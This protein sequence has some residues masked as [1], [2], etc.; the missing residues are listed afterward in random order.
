MTKFRMFFTVSLTLLAFSACGDSDA[1]MD[2]D[3]SA[4]GGACSESYPDCSFMIFSDPHIYDKSL[5]ID[6]EAFEE[7]LAHDRKLL[8]ESEE[9]LGV[10]VDK[11]TNSDVD[12]VL[13]PGD[14]TKDGA[15]V[16]HSLF[17]SY[18]GQ[19]EAA[20]ISVYVV[21]GNHDLYNPHAVSFFSDEVQQEKYV[22]P[23]EFAAIYSDF[24]FSEAL[25][26]DESSLSYVVE[27]VD[28]LWILCMDSTINTNNIEEDY[29]TT[30]GSFKQNT[31]TWM[32]TVLNEAAD[33][34]KAVFA[35][36]HHGLIPHWEGQEKLHN[37]YV[38]EGYQSLAAYLANK[39]VKAVFTGHYHSQDIAKESFNDDDFIF[40][41]ETGSL[42]TYPC[43]IRTVSIAENMMEIRSD[44]ITAIPS[45]L[46]GFTKYAA[47][48]VYDGVYGIADEIIQDFGVKAD[49]SAIIAAEIGDAYLAHY[50]GDEDPNAYQGIEKKG[51]G[52]KGRLVLMN[53][54]YVLEGLWADTETADN[55]VMINLNTGEWTDISE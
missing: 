17:A 34:G 21:P 39:N 4:T 19:I 26:T 9:L 15:E 49:Q 52:F 22:S 43:P 40:D 11:I 45:H 44:T 48:F 35:I 54:K 12:F 33:Q 47:D 46:E 27:P 42:V 31:I 10:A 16:C 30:D 32:D 24:G 55:D 38:I 25:Y 18:L 41:V 6:G 2:L 13:V 3:V 28:G 7:Y 36:F 20:G 51:L 14:L 23:E 37:E 53:Q 8:V 50:A 5:G 1:K 29:P